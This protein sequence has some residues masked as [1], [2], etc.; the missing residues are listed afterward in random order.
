MGVAR[1]KVEI[2]RASEESFKLHQSSS[3]RAVRPK[4]SKV[5]IERVNA[6]CH[7][8]IS[9]LAQRERSQKL[10]ATATVKKN[11]GRSRLERIFR[12]RPSRTTTMA[13]IKTLERCPDRPKRRRP[14]RKGTRTPVKGVRWRL[15]LNNNATG[16]A[17][18]CISNPSIPSAFFVVCPS[19]H[20][21]SSELKS[22]KR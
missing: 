8:A 20:S 21:E 3:R 5:D 11:E 15:A 19:S 7:I 6:N 12:L 4:I 14:T 13:I 22:L 2:A 16:G 18:I 10:T 1:T 9:A 17:T